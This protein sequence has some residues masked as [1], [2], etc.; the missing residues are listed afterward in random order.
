MGI[1][2]STLGGP[3]CSQEINKWANPWSYTVD[4]NE[5]CKQLLKQKLNIEKELSREITKRRKIKESVHKLKEEVE[6]LQA[7]TTNPK[8]ARRGSSSKS[9]E[10]YS[11]QQCGNIKKRLSSEIRSALPPVV[12]STLNHC[13]SNW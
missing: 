12:M 1:S 4:S 11:R 5:E 10:S 6:T 2:L 13:P 8:G 7:Q 9:W 3:R